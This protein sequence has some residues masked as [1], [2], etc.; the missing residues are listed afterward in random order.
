MNMNRYMHGQPPAAGRLLLLAASFVATAVQA[1][2]TEETK[3]LPVVVVTAEQE[4]KQSLGVSI[5]TAEE[6]ERHPPANDISEILR[7]MPGVNLTG[8]SPSGQRGNNRQIDIRGMGPENTLILIDGKP[9]NSRNSVRYGWRGERDTRGDTNWVPSDQIER[10]EVLRGPAAARY[11]NGAAGGVVNIITKKASD[12]I[13]G[14]VSTYFNIP[15]HSEEGDTQRMSFGLNGPLSETLSFRLYGSVAK[16]DSDDIDINKDHASRRIGQNAN[17]LPAGREGVRNRDLNGALTLK[18]LSGHE[19]EFSVGTS[20]QGNIYTGDTQNTN[21][22]V[23]VQRNIGKETNRMY[24][25]TYALTHRADWNSDTQTLSYLQYEKTRNSRLLE[26]LAGGTDGAFNNP[27]DGDGGFGDIDLKTI[28]AHA[29]INR[30]FDLGGIPNMGTIG[31]EWV[32]ARLED[33]ASNLAARANETP[34]QPQRVP[35][36]PVAYDP[37]VSSKIFSIFAEDNIYMTDALIATPGLRFDHHDEYGS[38]WSPFFNI[39]YALSS[40]LTLKGGIARAYKA[41]N[42]Y[43]GNPG[44]A[45]YSA[46]NGCYGG[47]RGCFLVGNQNLEPETSVNKEIGLEYANDDLIASIAYFRND[48]RNKVEAGITS[49]GTQ[50]GRDIFQWSNI[51][52]AIAEG[53]EGNLTLPLNKSLKWSTNFTYMIQSENKSTGE[54][55]SVIPEYTVNSKLDWKVNDSL[56]AGAYATWYGTQKPQR[57]DYYGR[58]NTGTATDEVK[59]Y[60]LFGINGAYRINQRFQLTA[61]IDNLFDKRLYRRGNA[62]GVNVGTPHEISGAGAHTYNQ[63]GR[64]YFASLNASF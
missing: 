62:V 7:T 43:Q 24:R 38:N 16:T 50:L 31:M 60:A 52:R 1:A 48:Y 54:R 45:Q 17:S 47:L 63:P 13:S 58:P 42:L 2:T 36:P 57:F 59:P 22:N 44:Y 49:V 15:Q 3:E 39:S 40:S 12:K 35:T 53:L 9:V 26:G 34:G 27:D 28:T 19:I 46:G 20:R 8:N 25:Q 64:L 10:V 29:E 33:P 18:P 61:G 30:R 5:I 14:N 11:G 55:L 41:P 37:K 23:E 6:L 32:H 4:L 21:T 51:P 56:S